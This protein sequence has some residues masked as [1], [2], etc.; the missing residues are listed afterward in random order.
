MTAEEEWQLTVLFPGLRNSTFKITSSPDFTY[1]CVAWVIGITNEWWE[2]RY[3][4]GTWP[5]HI[6]QERTVAAAILALANV[7]YEECGDGRIEENVEK[8][9]IYG[10]RDQFLHVA[11]QLP[12]GR[13]SSKLGRAWDIEHELEALTS[14]ANLG[15]PVQYGEVVAYMRR[16]QPG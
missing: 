8:V 1:N 16:E 5:D 7:S 2:P 13:W 9:A 10:A 3:R 14:T 12:S 4:E 11:K 6:P 15:G